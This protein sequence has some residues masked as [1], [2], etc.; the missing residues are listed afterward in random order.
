M[1]Y[2]LV[3]DT[4]YRK[5]FDIVKENRESYAILSKQP[6]FFYGYDYGHGYG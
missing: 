5:A 3:S 4:K 6:G 2:I 1:D